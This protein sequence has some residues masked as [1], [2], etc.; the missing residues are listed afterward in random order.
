[1][2]SNTPILK[3]VMALSKQ[4]SINI[5]A[6]VFCWNFRETIV[7]ERCT[8]KFCQKHSKN[9]LCFKDIGDRN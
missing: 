9:H 6:C 4:D 2:S 3:S 8:K 5:C 1:M 7:C